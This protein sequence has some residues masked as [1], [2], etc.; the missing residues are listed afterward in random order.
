MTQINQEM[1]QKIRFNERLYATEGDTQTGHYLVHPGQGPPAVPVGRVHCVDGGDE[2]GGLAV[3]VLFRVLLEVALRVVAVLLLRDHTLGV[4]AE[5]LERAL[6]LVILLPQLPETQNK[7][8]YW[9]SSCIQKTWR[10]GEI[11]LLRFIKGGNSPIR[12]FTIF[13]NPNRKRVRP[14]FHNAFKMKIK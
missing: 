8:L 13:R 1:D 6:Q 11:R 5:L 3:A 12:Q 2:G 9:T 14:Y 7:D 4:H 10:R